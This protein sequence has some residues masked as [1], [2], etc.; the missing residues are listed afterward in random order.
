M[1]ASALAALAVGLATIRLRGDYLA[2]STFGIAMVIQLVAVN[3]EPVTGGS[4]GLASISRPLSGL[5][6]GA[7]LYNLFFLG[8]VAALVVLVYF[9]LQRIVRSPWG[10]VLRALR[11]DET[12]AVSLGKNA[13]VY[14]LQAFMLGAALIGLSGALYVTFIGFVS[15]TDFL[16]LVTFQLWAML[17]VGGSGNNRGALLGALVVWGLW[18]ASGALIFKLVPPAYHSQGA[19]IQ[20]ILIG[21]LLVAML[22]FR[23]RGLIGEETVISRHLDLEPPGA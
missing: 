21:L 18:T 9:A 22:L 2:I 1:V 15:P 7:D 14:R 19:A 12:A 3:W 13:T 20:A 6:L 4:Q 8:L 16:P 5:M 11:E 23:P 17:I 10:R